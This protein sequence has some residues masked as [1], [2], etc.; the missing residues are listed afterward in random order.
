MR[1]LIIVLIVLVSFFSCN[2]ES[3]DFNGKKNGYVV[4]FFDN[5]DTLKYKKLKNGLNDSIEFEYYIS[6]NL[7]QRLF[8]DEGKKYSNNY[9]YYDSSST[10]FF[11]ENLDTMAID[12]FFL[13]RHEFYFPKGN[14]HFYRDFDIEGNVINE[15]GSNIIFIQTDNKFTVE[16]KCDIR[17][18]SIKPH[19]TETYLVYKLYRDNVFINTDTLFRNDYIGAYFYNDSIKNSGEFRIKFYSFIRDLGSERISVDSVKFEFKIVANKF[20]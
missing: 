5:G 7:K 13:K 15:G 19:N 1:Y 12:S 2:K 17:V 18:Y 14:L 3:K 16:K 10:R 4:T 9:Y 8:W 6:G 11:R 20:I